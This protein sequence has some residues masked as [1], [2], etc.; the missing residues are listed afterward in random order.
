VSPT[1]PLAC[2]TLVFTRNATTQPSNK[3]NHPPPPPPTEPTN[4]PTR[5]QAL[6]ALAANYGLGSADTVLL[7][8]CSAG[9]LATYL[10]TDYV[11][12]QVAA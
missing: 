3:T 12:Q 5:T 7:T 10:H 4:R 8:G 9:G 11:H 2:Q 1:K 6:K